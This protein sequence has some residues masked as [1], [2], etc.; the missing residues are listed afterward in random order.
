MSLLQR[1]WREIHLRDCS[2]F[3]AANGQLATPSASPPAAQPAVKTPSVHTNPA[4]NPADSPALPP[5]PE[6]FE[7]EV[8]VSA[9]SSADVA[10]AVSGGA[11]RW[12]WVLKG[13]KASGDDV[14]FSCLY[15]PGAIDGKQVY[16]ASRDADVT[17]AAAFSRAE[18]SAGSFVAP[19]GQG[20]LLL[21]FDNVDAW[22]RAKAVALKLVMSGTTAE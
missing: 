8:F 10:V 13:A 22:W 7:Q 6:I 15:I 5:P 2:C 20:V 14:G 11:V 19:D 9:G 4:Y 16:K 1:D 18:S 21:R 17:E 3:Q 12:T